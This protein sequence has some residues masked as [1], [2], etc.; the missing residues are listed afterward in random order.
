[1][2]L[3]PTM[4][5]LPFPVMVYSVVQALVQ[6]GAPVI[7]ALSALLTFNFKVVLAG[8]VASQATVLG[9]SAEER[10]WILETKVP[11]ADGAARDGSAY[12]IE[13]AMNRTAISLVL[14]RSLLIMFFI[15]LSTLS[16]LHIQ[17]LIGVLFYFYF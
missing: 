8:T 1:M 6:S 10:F 5:V 9:Y 3:F 16:D 17:Y 11:V 2:Q 7:E 14:I 15:F 4:L 13:T 12:R